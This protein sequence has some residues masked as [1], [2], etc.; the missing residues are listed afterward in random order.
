MIETYSSE[1]PAGTVMDQNPKAGSQVDEGSTVNL[2]VSLG[3][4][5]ADVPKPVTKQLEIDLPADIVPGEP[6]QMTVTMKGETIF[7]E[8]VDTAMQLSVPVSVTGTGEQVVSVY[9]NG[10]LHH[11]INVNFSE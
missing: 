4:D 10:V 5:P 3:P 2:Q 6:L 11:T 8:T 1:I 9:F 7:N